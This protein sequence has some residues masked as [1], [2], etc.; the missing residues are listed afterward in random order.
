MIERKRKEVAQ[1]ELRI[2]VKQSRARTSSP[3]KR[4]DNAVKTPFTDL[5]NSINKNNLFII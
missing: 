3:L 2:D 5:T 1:K 4:T